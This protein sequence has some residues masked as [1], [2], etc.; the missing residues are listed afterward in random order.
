MKRT[1]HC[2]VCGKVYEWEEKGD[3]P[4]ENFEFICLDCTVFVMFELPKKIKVPRRITNYLNLECGN[5][6]RAALKLA[7]LFFKQCQV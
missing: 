1:N 5:G 6:N 4:E 2:P 7:N 3:G